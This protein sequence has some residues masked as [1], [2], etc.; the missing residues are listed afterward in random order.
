MK[1][2]VLTLAM[3]FVFAAL[4]ASCSTKE[5]EPLPPAEVSADAAAR[6]TAP[7]DAEVSDLSTEAEEDVGGGTDGTIPKEKDLLI[8]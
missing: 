2:M 5:T 7:Q 3:L 4:A 6:E 8:L 1:K